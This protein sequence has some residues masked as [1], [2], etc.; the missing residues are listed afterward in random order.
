MRAQRQRTV[1][2]HRTGN[3][4]F[5]LVELLVVIAVIMLLAALI[6]P[7]TFRA[8]RLA[9]RTEC[10]SNLR[11]FGLALNVYR[12][13]Y[14]RYP[15]QRH[16]S[17][18]YV[19]EGSL[20]GGP[21]LDSIVKYKPYPVPLSM[22]GW[23]ADAMVAMGLGAEVV[24]DARVPLPKSCRV[25]WCPAIRR[26]GSIRETY[27]PN[28]SG[29]C[30]YYG[31][32]RDDCYDYI[33]G[34]FYVGGTHYWRWAD[35]PNS[36]CVVEDPGEWALASDMIYYMAGA[37]KVNHREPGL[38]GPEG[39]NVLFADGQVG[40]FRW[41]APHVPVEYEAGSDFN[42]RYNNDWGGSGQYRNYWRRTRSA[43]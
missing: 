39:A 42:F 32:A 31:N 5:T 1:R 15:H 37:W 12:Q 26:Q 4:G 11:Q 24:K 8:R 22:V 35:E 28:G 23:E 6:L 2:A 16:T 10:V 41:N 7:A 29:F 27:W 25:L 20:Q 34:Y 19:K 21:L 43:P 33:L 9:L 17:G 13:A 18:N 30:G 3:C 14:G 40:W 36:P 38:P